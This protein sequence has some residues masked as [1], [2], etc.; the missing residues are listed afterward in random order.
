[1]IPGA[2]ALLRSRPW[3]VARVVAYARIALVAA[4]IAANE[5]GPD[6]EQA[7]FEHSAQT[8]ATAL[9]AKWLRQSVGVAIAKHTWR[10]VKAVVAGCEG[11]GGGGMHCAGAGRR[12]ARAAGGGCWAGVVRCPARAK[13]HGACG[14]G[15]SSGGGGEHGSTYNGTGS[16][17]GAG[18]R[19]AQGG[20]ACAGAGGHSGGAGRGSVHGAGDQGAGRAS[21]ERT[22]SGAAG[23]QQ[24][25]SQGRSS[26]GVQRGVWVDP[27]E[28]QVGDIAQHDPGAFAF[29]RW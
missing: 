20:V 3:L 16:L 4:R 8:W 14:W 29:G 26:G 28:Q 9:H 11:K 12:Q 27:R 25:S 15:G 21:S 19:Q 7:R 5:V 10:G 1:M 2:L 24:G 13:V 18:V 6:S 22:G 17:P 23:M